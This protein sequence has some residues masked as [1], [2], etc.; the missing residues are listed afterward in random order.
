MD[1]VY[2]AA[3]TRTLAWEQRVRGVGD[4][5]ALLAAHLRDEHHPQVAGPLA[6]RC[7]GLA[8]PRTAPT[9]ARAPRA[10]PTPG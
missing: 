2:R 9:G 5:H 3:H 8:R 6:P 4:F 1:Q 7:W 10:W